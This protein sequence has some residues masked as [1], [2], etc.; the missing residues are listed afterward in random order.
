MHCAKR[1]VCP[2][3]AW[4]FDAGGGCVAIPHA[5]G[6]ARREAEAAEA[7]KGRT[8]TKTKRTSVRSYASAVSQG[9]VW[10]SPSSPE[11]APP[12]SRL[13][14]LPEL[15]LPGW[16]SDDF[17]RDFDGIDFP[18][19]VQN[20][21]DPDH[22]LFAHQTPNFDAFSAAVG[23][24]MR[25]SK[26]MERSS[27]D[28]EGGGKNGRIVGRVEAAPVL[29]KKT[30]TSSSSTS[31]SVAELAFE[32]PCHVRWARLDAVEGEKDEEREKE[33]E[34]IAAFYVTPL[35]LGRSRL[36]VRYARCLFPRVRVPRPL[37]AMALNGFLDQVRKVKLEPS[38]LSFEIFHFHTKTRAHRKR[39]LTSFFFFFP[40]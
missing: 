13:S 23:M 17:V 5:P 6:A 16:V 29:T 25:V 34:F 30:S 27:G 8:T 1:L 11:N 38:R 14:T 20:V 33:A 22:G 4:T 26:T 19:L 31:S 28:E 9:L 10:L 15:D 7:E 35:G 40:S 36:F 39:F 24:P 2:Y 18:L 3:H 21:A 32:P 12:L 37:L